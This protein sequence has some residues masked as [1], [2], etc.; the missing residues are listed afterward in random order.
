MELDKKLVK[1]IFKSHVDRKLDL[2]TV[3]EEQHKFMLNDYSYY[4][5]YIFQ[6]NNNQGFFE[7]Q[8]QLHNIGL[9]EEKI[10]RLID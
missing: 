7:R 2:K 10:N 1:K 6:L 4:S 3:T 8:V 5:N 9:R